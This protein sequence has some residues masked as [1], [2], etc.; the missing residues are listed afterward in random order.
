MD[1]F[2]GDPAATPREKRLLRVVRM[3]VHGLATLAVAV[4]LIVFTVLGIK[5]E[6]WIGLVLTWI[7]FSAIIG[8]NLHLF[9]RARREYR[10]LGKEGDKEG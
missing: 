3:L 10:S 2:D 4:L 6:G 5:N 1:L 9:L 8:V 7:A